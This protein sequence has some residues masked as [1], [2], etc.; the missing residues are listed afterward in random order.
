[1]IIDKVTGNDRMLGV[2]ALKG[3]AAY[4]I[5]LM[6]HPL[7]VGFTT[8]DR[9]PFDQI[10]FIGFIE[11]NGWMSVELFLMISGF[12]FWIRYSE[13][14][15]QGNMSFSE[16][17]KK[18]IVRIFPT[19]WLAMLITVVLQLIYIKITGQW[20][21]IHNNSL[22]ELIFSFGGMENFWTP[23]SWNAPAWT[24]SLLI[25]CWTIFFYVVQKS[26]GVTSRQICSCIVL[27]MIGITIVFSPPEKYYPLINTTFARGYI[28]F[29]AGGI[30][31]IIYMK[32]GLPM[33]KHVGTVM[34]LVNIIFWGLFWI[35]DG[36]INWEPCGV[37]VPLIVWTTVLIITLVNKAIIKLLSTAPFQYL[38]NISFSLYL[39]NFPLE[40]IIKIIEIKGHIQIDYSSGW[41]L[42]FNSIY[43]ILVGGAV[44]YLYELRF[45]TYVT[46]KIERYN[47]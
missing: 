2:N 9:L 26:G 10:Y 37:T 42:L 20:F 45:S 23:Q 7:T 39:M 34:V 40:I 46:K 13:K 32:Y 16:F 5:A 22:M 31:G 29:F 19:M 4:C 12:L 43:Q 15:A 25:T 36:A 35:S 38:G 24:I 27:I 11:R 44:Y 33:L 14:I 3:I 6:F 17:L 18:R 30:I 8:N 28:S 47:F 1:M 21:I 41:F